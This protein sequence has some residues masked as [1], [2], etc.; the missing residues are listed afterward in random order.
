M[1]IVAPP[2]SQSPARFCAA[3][4]DCLPKIHERLNQSLGAKFMTETEWMWLQAL[5]LQRAAQSWCQGDAEGWRQR[6]AELQRRLAGR[7][8]AIRRRREACELC[9]TPP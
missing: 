6:D 9:A 5:R 1:R 2:P 7:N 8:P 3:Q 4:V